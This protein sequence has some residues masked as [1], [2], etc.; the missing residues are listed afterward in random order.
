MQSFDTTQRTEDRIA[1]YF[2]QTDDKQKNGS[3]DI[4]RQAR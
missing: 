1:I 4:Q 2:I 3:T